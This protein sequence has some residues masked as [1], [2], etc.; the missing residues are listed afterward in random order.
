MS[1]NQKQMEQNKQLVSRLILECF[2]GGHLHVIDEIVSPEFE[3]YYP[4]VPEGI[5]GLKAI[6]K[7]NNDSFEG[8]S[9][10]IHELFAEGDKV[11]ARWSA[12]G[13]HAKSFMGE[14]ST[15]EEVHLKGISIYEIQKGKIVKDWV[16]ADYVGFLTQLGVLSPVDFTE[17]K[18]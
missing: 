5:E 9:F 14:P 15:G 7:K 16:E 10:T 3:F 11:I 6:V 1:D 8:W 13:I 17:E 2:S 18:K 12:T 4:N